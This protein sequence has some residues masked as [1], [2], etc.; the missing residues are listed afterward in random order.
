MSNLARRSYM[1]PVKPPGKYPLT[2]TEARSWPVSNKISPRA[3]SMTKT[4]IARGGVHRREVSSH[5]YS[6][7]RLP[8]ECSGWICTVPVLITETAFTPP[9]DPGSER[10][11]GIAVFMGQPRFAGRSLGFARPLRIQ[12]AVG[13]QLRQ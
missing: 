4:L 6:G 9:G 13:R 7:L 11:T 8:Y 1:C 10:A 5:K 12:A 2:V 3:C